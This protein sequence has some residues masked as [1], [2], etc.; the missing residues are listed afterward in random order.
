M[1]LELRNLSLMSYA[2]LNTIWYYRTEDK[3][4]EV[5]GWD[6]FK[7][8]KTILKHGDFIFV[9]TVTGGLLLWVDKSKEA[10]IIKE[11]AYTR[12]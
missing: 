3:T 9:T 8:A 11:M 12:K 6:Y 4:S 10:M 7:D 2:Q 5:L 1:A